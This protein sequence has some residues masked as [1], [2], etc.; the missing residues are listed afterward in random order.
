MGT[1]SN[2]NEHF[3][4][5]SLS[6]RIGLLLAHPIDGPVWLTN[7][8][9]VLLKGTFEPNLVK[10]QWLRLGYTMYKY[11]FFL[12]TR[13]LFCKLVGPKHHECWFYC[14][15][16]LYSSTLLLSLANN[17]IAIKRYH[18][19]ICSIISTGKRGGFLQTAMTF[20]RPN[21]NKILSIFK[22]KVYTV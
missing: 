11:F 14:G 6:K 12:I 5:Y 16:H 3:L 4:F 2:L 17:C 8:C 22:W 13:N 10:L 21:S 1:N 15:S 18:F 9:I 19:N 20:F 7:L